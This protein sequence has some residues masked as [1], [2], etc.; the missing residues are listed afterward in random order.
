MA[1]RELSAFT[2]KQQWPTAWGASGKLVITLSR[3]V[4]YE[5][6]SYPETSKR[7]G[8][9]NTLGFHWEAAITVVGGVATT[10]ALPGLIN[11][12]TATPS[13]V[14]T[15]D[16]YI[17]DARG[18]MRE[19]LNTTKPYH[20]HESLNGNAATFTWAQW[21]AE[22]EFVQFRGEGVFVGDSV[23]VQGMITAHSTPLTRTIT[24]TSPLRIGGAASADLSANR[25]LSVLDASTSQKGVTRLS[26]APVSASEPIAVGDN[27]PRMLSRPPEGAAGG[28]LSGAYPRPMISQY[29]HSLYTSPILSILPN[30]TVAGWTYA[31]AIAIRNTA[32]IDLVG[33]Q[34]RLLLDSSN[35]SFSQ[36]RADGFDV[37]FYDE[38]GTALTFRRLSYSQANMTAAFDVKLPTITAGTKGVIYLLYGNASATDASSTDGTY[39][40]YT[41]DSKTTNLWH[42]D[43]GSG[44]S[45]ANAGTSAVAMTLAGTP[46][47]AAD[48]RFAAG[49]SVT[50]NGTTQYMTAAVSPDFL[51]PGT[52]EF[53]W[54]PTAGRGVGAGG[55]HLLMKNFGDSSPGLLNVLDI[56]IDNVTGQLTV[57]IYNG[58][59]F[60]LDLTFRS[61]ATSWNAG[62]TYHVVLTWNL[63][64]SFLYI[65]GVLQSKKTLLRPGFSGATSG[66]NP[67][68]FTFGAYNYT[69]TPSD[70][71]AATFDEIAI[72]ERTKYVTEITAN[73]EYRLPI[74]TNQ[75]DKWVK[76][77]AATI[78]PSTTYEGFVGAQYGLIL[79]PSL[80]VN[81]DGSFSLFYTSYNTTTN[82][83]TVSRMTC[84][85]GS[86]PTVG[87][88]WTRDADNPHIGRGNGGAGASENF[89]RS[90]VVRNDVTLYAFGTAS[91]AGDPLVLYT[92]SIT[93]QTVWT[94][95]GTILTTAAI[96]NLTAF[97]NTTVWPEKQVDGYYYGLVDGFFSDS[98]VW[99]MFAIRSTSLSSG[100][101][102]YGTRLTTMQPVALG[103]YGGAWLIRKGDLWHAWYQYGDHPGQNSLNDT[104]NKNLP[105]PMAHATSRDMTTWA[106]SA[107]S[108]AV[109][110]DVKYL[111]LVD[112]Q[113]ADLT[114]LE[115]GG[116]VYGAAEA[117][118]NFA[119][120]TQAALVIMSF[121]G[122]LEDLTSR[123][124][125]AEFGRPLPLTA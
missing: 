84:P 14:A 19:K 59:G 13:H 112:D 32:G 108:P 116:K 122:T 28:D 4:V 49:N 35:F 57:F 26:V 124:L 67:Q 40:K 79:E 87:A 18:R 41:A 60:A 77:S 51:K 92:A 106:I 99:E 38:R 48:T 89:L 118:N 111:P 42:L 45:G 98:N 110:I 39:A 17:Y 46:T 61:L 34:L 94:K 115:H 120:T 15:Y 58:T 70:F 125:L 80:L 29:P 114:L 72:L 83:G 12:D 22:M 55:E 43:D 47:W 76:P 109:A 50:L 123:G 62:Q 7:G 95:V 36:A 97:G 1:T 3:S 73:L 119:G 52:I 10:A 20:I 68:V 104:T 103:M 8:A 100:W 117:H 5:S 11:T 24:T 107:Q 37:R 96:A 93:A 102:V 56:F 91:T 30:F 86:D 85:A 54:K 66:T 121:T 101:A 81:D 9:L 82:E 23:T 53:R 88:N 33:R 78:I 21:I 71:A 64:H 16:I 90:C 69:G 31:K 113:L 75:I 2:I 25:T 6:V 65:D 63:T 74:P 105:T 27:D 44:A